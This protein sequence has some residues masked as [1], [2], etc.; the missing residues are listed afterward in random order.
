MLA[1]SF[2]VLAALLYLAQANQASVLDLNIATL[3]N[4]QVQLNSQNVDLRA[5]SMSLQSIQRIDSIAI[6]QLHMAK[7]DASNTIWI[8]PIIPIVSTPRA[9]GQGG[10]SAQQD[11]QP[12]AW[13]GRFLNA[14]QSS[15]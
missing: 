1:M 10:Y 5:T 11:S 6:N 15:L 9:T 13:V 8:Y 4:E 12:M 3:Q 2:T 7:P 14:V